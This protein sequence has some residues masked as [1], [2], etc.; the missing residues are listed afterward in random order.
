MQLVLDSRANQLIQSCACLVPQPVEHYGV[1]ADDDE[2]RQKIGRDEEDGL[3]ED[4]ER[5]GPD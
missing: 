3:Q 1:E 2:E 5:E 4:G